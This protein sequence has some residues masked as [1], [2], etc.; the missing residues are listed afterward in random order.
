M[1]RLQRISIP[2]ALKVYRFFLELREP[3][4]DGQRVDLN[5]KVMLLRSLMV[6]ASPMPI[7]FLV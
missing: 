7:V 5:L 1:T 2:R 6:V 3:S 4:V